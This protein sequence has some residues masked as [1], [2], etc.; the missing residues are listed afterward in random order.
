MER[1]HFALPHQPLEVAPIRAPVIPATAPPMFLLM[2]RNAQVRR[3][4]S[5]QRS[6]LEHRLSFIAINNCLSNNGNCGA[7]STCAYTGPGTNTCTCQNG[8]VSPTNDGRSC[9]PQCFGIFLRAHRVNLGTVCPSTLWTGANCDIPGSSSHIPLGQ[10]FICSCLQFAALF[11]RTQALA[12]WR[13]VLAP[14]CALARPHGLAQAAPP[15]VKHNTC[16]LFSRN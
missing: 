2:A 5:F 4:A 11:A 3:S 16:L 15:Q 1:I 10:S 13:P 6:L 7:H 14:T 12:L 9:L 8:W